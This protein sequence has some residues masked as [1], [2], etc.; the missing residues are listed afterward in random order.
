M[1]YAYTVLVADDDPTVLEV[2]AQILREPGY[3]VV[4]ARDGFEAIRILAERHVD[5]MIADIKMPGLDGAELASQAKVMRPRLHVIYI[6]GFLD[7]R[8]KARSNPLLEKPI[9]AAALIEAIR[10]TMSAA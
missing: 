10:K 4:T 8:Q 7:Q 1:T 5:L 2:V 3:A 6:T 9:R